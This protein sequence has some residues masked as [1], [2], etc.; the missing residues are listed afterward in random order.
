[1]YVVGVT[2]KPLAVGTDL[3]VD[4]VDGPCALRCPDSMSWYVLTVV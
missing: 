2:L 1:M 3:A 4:R